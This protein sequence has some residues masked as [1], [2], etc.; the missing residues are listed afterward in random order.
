MRKRASLFVI[1]VFALAAIPA[2]AQQAPKVEISVGYSPVRS[3]LVSPGG[4]CF[5]MNG[6]TGSVAYNVKPWLGL[7]GELGG[8]HAGNI[9]NAGADLNLFSYLFGPQFYFRRSEWITP[10]GHV[11]LGGAHAGGTL[12]TGTPGA[13]GL[14]A[15]THFAAAIGGGIDGNV[16]DRLSIRFIQADY[17]LTTFGNRSNDHQNNLRITVGIVFRFG[18]R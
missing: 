1:V 5:G 10:F 6:A 8:Y 18:K 17:Y 9:K 16:T 13:P 12:F 15:Q 4:C 2:A 3:N 7:V 11:L 14:G